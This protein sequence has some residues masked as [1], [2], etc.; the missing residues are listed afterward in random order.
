MFSIWE[1]TPSF[2]KK[3]KLIIFHRKYMTTMTK[4]KINGIYN[5]KKVY[6]ESLCDSLKG[7]VNSHCLTYFVF[8]VF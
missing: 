2:G 1:E 4:N 7:N 6:G 8:L 3:K 5:V